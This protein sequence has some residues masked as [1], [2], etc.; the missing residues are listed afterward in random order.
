MEWYYILGIIS[1]GIFIIQF[2]LSNL[3]IGDMDLDVDCDGN[4]DFG[5]S[6]LLSFKGLTHFVMGFSGWLMLN[7]QVTIATIIGAVIVGII[8]VVALF[9]LYKLCMK[10]NYEPTT[11]SG[12]A[13]IGKKVVVYAPL[14][15]G[16]SS[17]YLMDEPYTEIVCISD[18]PKKQG[19]ICQII[20]FNSGIYNIS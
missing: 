6:D 19:E 18:S 1:Y 2:I 15:D 4:I 11:K 7:G 10:F 12:S 5:A 16:R 17:C 13:L 8:F 3:G 9:F 14:S 20:A